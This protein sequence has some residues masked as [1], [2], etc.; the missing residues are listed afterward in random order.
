MQ[1]PSRRS[2]PRAVSGS[3]VVL[4][5]LLGLLLTGMLPLRPS[6]ASGPVASV[7][8]SQ[9]PLGPRT[10]TLRAASGSVAAGT[11]MSFTLAIT[12]ANCLTG[13]PPDEAVVSVVFVFG[14]GARLPTAGVINERSCTGAPWNET[15]STS[16]DYIDTG[17]FDASAVVAWGDGYTVATNP[18]PISVRPANDPVGTAMSGFVIGIGIAAA[19]TL[20]VVFWARRALP[21]PPGLRWSEI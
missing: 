14:D 19:A 9:S 12:G 2:P 16:Y 4:A 17:T 10:A 5:V 20:L 7:A 18:V 15:V 3:M 13:A 11:D 21:P 8:L 6:P 1:V